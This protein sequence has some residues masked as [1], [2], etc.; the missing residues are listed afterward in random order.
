MAVPEGNAV[1]GNVF[2]PNIGP[3]ERRKR[4]L[5]GVVGFFLGVG[6]LALLVVLSVDRWW[7]LALVL[8]FWMA[9]IGFFQHRDKT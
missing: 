2:V 4:L 1:T 8:P 9:G 5:V 3:G 6:A 7:R